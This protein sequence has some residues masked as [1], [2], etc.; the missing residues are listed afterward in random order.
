LGLGALA[1]SGTRFVAARNAVEARSGKLDVA[2]IRADI[3]RVFRDSFIVVPN[4]FGLG[5]TAFRGSDD[6]QSPPLSDDF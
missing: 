4:L 5:G 2:A 1:R 3:D 6:A